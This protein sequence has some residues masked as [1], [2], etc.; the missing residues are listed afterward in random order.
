MKKKEE[1]KGGKKW[2]EREGKKKMEGRRRG[3]KI[4]ENEGEMRGKQCEAR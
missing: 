4:K 1:A 2:K 3:E